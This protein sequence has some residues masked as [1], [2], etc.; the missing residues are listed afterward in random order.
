MPPKQ[1]FYQT[2]GLSKG[3]SDAEVKRAYRE[4]ARKLHPDVVDAK[5]RAAAESRFKEINEAYGVLSDPA[6]RAQY[7]AFGF[8]P[9]GSSSAGPTVGDVSD[10]FDVFFGGMSGPRRGAGPTRG[11]DLRYQLEISLEDVLHGAEREITF[12]FLGRCET[13]DGT[14]SSDRSAPARCPQCGGAGQVRSARSTILGQFVTSTTCPRCH[15]S[16]TI[17]TKPCKT[18]AGHGRH[19]QRQRVSVRIPKGIED[20]T[21]LRYQGYGESGERGAQSGDLYVF[22]AVRPHDVFERDGA[23]L[24]CS[25]AVSFTQAALG[26]T[27][28]IET[29]DGTAELNLPAGAQH[30]SRYRIPN[31]GLPHLRGSGRGDLY[32]DVEVRVPTKLTKKQRELLVEFA[33]AGGEDISEDKTFVRKVKEAFGVD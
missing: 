25:T 33:R 21:R 8:V 27:L 13:C 12:N 17:V 29:L 10:L 4:L 3:A 30:G 7:D 5:E 32:V 14:G 23:D 15:G 26:A 24:H 19:E 6:K 18:C 20:G 16:G 2:L 9:G 11:A 1:D 28:E 31:R 22:V